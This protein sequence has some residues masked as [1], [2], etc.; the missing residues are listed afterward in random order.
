MIR[1]SK[2]D[3]IIN[4]V[5]NGYMADSQIVPLVP[6]ELSFITIPLENK[7]TKREVYTVKITDPDHNLVERDEV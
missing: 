4:Q 7:S 6:G 3:L 1:Q 5:L 2:K